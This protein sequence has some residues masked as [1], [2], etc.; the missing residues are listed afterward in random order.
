MPRRL[1]H[2]GETLADALRS[3]GY[4]AI[5][6]TDEVR[7]AN[8][9]ESYGFD[10]LVTPP[11]GAVDF[12]LGYAGDM[13]L[14]NL[15]A[16][17][18][19][20]RTLFPSNHANRAAQVTY[21]PGD[22]VDASN[23]SS[24]GSPT[25]LA[26]HLTLTHWPYSWAGMSTPSTP[27]EYASPMVGPSRLSIGSSTRSCD[28]SRTRAY[29]TTLSSCCCQITAK[30]SAAKQ[31]PCCVRPAQAARSGTRCGDTVRVS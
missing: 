16:S 5:Y 18:A 31:I 11:I 7:F 24:G 1:V 20:G 10:Q 3:A 17:T 9:D 27:Q 12:L 2:E 4:H 13:P 14:V 28:C 15:V 21:G 23:A 22:F 29:L 25:L 30:R 8:I 19:A 26:I 6:S